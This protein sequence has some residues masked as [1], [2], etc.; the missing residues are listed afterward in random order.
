D[1]GRGISPLLLQR[2]FEPFMQVDS[3]LDRQHGG[4]GL[5]LTL[6]RSLVE[7]HG[8]SVSATSPGP[9]QGSAFTVR[10]PRLEDRPPPLPEKPT[11]AAPPA[12]TPP[13]GETADGPDPRQ[14]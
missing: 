12:N 8:G 6:V 2:I 4:L 14:S 3:S 5:G 1:N 13:S 10:L 9:G 11:P 7:L